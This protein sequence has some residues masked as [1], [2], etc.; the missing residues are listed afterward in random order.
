[1][2]CQANDAASQHLALVPFATTLL[3]GS[4]QRRS[5]RSSQLLSQGRFFSVLGWRP[6]FDQSYYKQRMDE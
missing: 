4:E 6:L 3:P 5:R 1:M 2:R